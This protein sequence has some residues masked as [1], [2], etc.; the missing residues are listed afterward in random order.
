MSMKFK[1]IRLDKKDTSS[2]LLKPEIYVY[3]CEATRKKHK[4]ISCEDYE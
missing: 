4:I 3:K 2:N 1:L